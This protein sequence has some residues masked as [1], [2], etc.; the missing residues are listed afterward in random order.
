[1]KRGGGGGMQKKTVTNTT[2][3]RIKE[4][5]DKFWKYIALYQN[6]SPQFRSIK[7]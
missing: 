7:I 6:E 2:K 5:E 3:V 4:N 1:M